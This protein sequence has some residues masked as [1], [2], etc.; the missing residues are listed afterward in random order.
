MNIEQHL[1]RWTKHEGGDFL[2]KHAVRHYTLWETQNIHTPVP[3]SMGLKTVPVA[4]KA[5][6]LTLYEYDNSDLLERYPN[7]DPISYE[8]D[9]QLRQPDE[10]Y[11]N[12]SVLNIYNDKDLFAA[13]LKVMKTWV[14]LGSY[15]YEQLEAPTPTQIPSGPIN[16]P[17]LIFKAPVHVQSQSSSPVPPDAIPGDGGTPI[18]LRF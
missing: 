18:E 11:V 9:V 5:Y 8:L 1:S 10:Q 6:Q 3:G 2:R 17:H 13:T 7:A 15:T 14:A 4:L 12:L 16:R